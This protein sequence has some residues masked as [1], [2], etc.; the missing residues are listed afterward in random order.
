MMFMASLLAPARSAALGLVAACCTAAAAAPVPVPPSAETTYFVEPVVDG[1]VDHAAALEQAWGLRGVPLEE[2]AFAALLPVL[3]SA[4]LEDDDAA[5]LRARLGLPPR[6]RP[7]GQLDFVEFARERGVPA[8]ADGGFGEPPPAG[9]PTASSFDLL[10][11]ATQA[12][13][14]REQLP[15]VGEWLDAADAELD[16]AAA[17]LQRPR[18]AVP[19]VRSGPKGMLL[20]ALLVNL[21][22]PRTLSKAFLA[23]AMLALGEEDAASALAD[24]RSIRL[25]ATHLSSEPSMIGRLVGLASEAVARDL[26]PLILSRPLTDEQL[27]GIATTLDANPD[28]STLPEAIAVG[29]RAVFLDNLQQ[30]HRF[31]LRPPR[32]MPPD[33]PGL[34]A[35]A[36]AAAP[37]FDLAAALRR[38]NVRWDAWFTRIPPGVDEAAAH[39]AAIEAELEGGREAREALLRVPPTAGTPGSIEL[40]QAVADDLCALGAGAFAFNFRTAR[41]V[42][43]G[44]PIARAAVAAARFRAATGSLPDTLDE[45][46]PRFLEA[47]PPDPFRPGPL[48]YALTD[49]GFTVWSVGVDGVD[50]GGTSRV[51]DLLFRVGEDGRDASG[52]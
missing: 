20:D 40:A 13:W 48:R 16:L 45:L 49:D 5:P 32:G 9:A 22:P 28:E 34:Y 41:E 2:N 10:D 44:E 4:G 38:V 50:D 14:T 19:I 11:E 29:E 51:D 42:E 7:R 15:L 25:L 33:F 26:L 8:F 3:E 24:W 39:F 18:W 27:E 12:P 52:G 23:R 47:L 37:G 46:V 31:S 21:P 35:I 36:Q 43:A 17:A 30:A 1:W 6:D